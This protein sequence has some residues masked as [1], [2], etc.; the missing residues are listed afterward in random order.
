[1]NNQLPPE[2][3]VETAAKYLG[4]T[5]RTVIN[6]L[7]S[8][9]IKG[10]KVG[11][12]W[13]IKSESLLLIRPVQTELNQFELPA[14]E[15]DTSK[16]QF[17]NKNKNSKKSWQFKKMP[18]RSP[19]N[20]NCFLRLQECYVLLKNI[21]ADISTDDFIFFS[22]ELLAIADDL[23]AGYYGFGFTKQ[24][25]YSRA[26]FRS[27]RVVGRAIMKAMP[28]G[29]FVSLCG[30]VEAISYLCRKIDKIKK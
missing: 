2:V 30:V 14:L 17:E 20:L 25:I 19:K 23:A 13:F 7:N 11:K 24:K 1:L 10:E 21:E 15:N 28:D 3:D 16:T 8:R 29:F 9:Q 18:S 22:A 5:A 4:I 6:Y 27:G 12:K 26:R